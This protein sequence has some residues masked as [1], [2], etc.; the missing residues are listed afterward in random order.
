[1]NTLSDTGGPPPAP[2]PNPSEGTNNGAWGN[3]LAM[4]VAQPQQQ[5]APAPSHLQVVAGL[6]HFG[7]IE[8]EL[9]GLLADPDTGKAD[10]RSQIIDATTKLVGERLV[11]PAEAVAQLG[12]VPE[13]PFEQKMFLERFLAQTIQAKNLLLDQHGAAFAGQDFQSP[14]YDE[15]NHGDIINGLLAHYKGLNGN[16]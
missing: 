14:E 10:I 8:K 5:P 3:A 6:R 7:A 13:R 15:D 4:P 12:K 11:T 9:M 1:M 2:N 16:A